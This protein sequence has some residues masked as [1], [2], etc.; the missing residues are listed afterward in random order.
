M[1]FSKILE[2]F[3]VHRAKTICELM[4]VYNKEPN[5]KAKER[6]L[7]VFNVVEEGETI[8]TIAQLFH[9]SYNSIKNWVMRFKKF[10]I[11]G[12]YE[13]PRS[14]RPTKIVNHKITEFF[15][16]VKNGIFPK[17]LVRQIKKDTGVS[18]TESGIRDMLRRHNFTPKVQDSTHKNKA[19]NE[20]IEEWQKALKWWLSCVKRDDF[21]MYVIDETILLQDYVPKCGPW[22]PKGQKVLQ[23]YFGDHQRRV[24]Y[25]AIS[26]LHQ[27]FLQEKN[28]TIQHFSSL[29]K[30]C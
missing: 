26:D 22:S 23:T 6:M 28:S 9:K 11:A 27:Y 19:T 18:Y 29:L 13:K 2:T 25:G 20:E 8:S 3:I 4:Y 10:G 14:G 7:A 1:Q 16:S 5:P 17:Q 24:I 21:E 15:A 12:L 30:N